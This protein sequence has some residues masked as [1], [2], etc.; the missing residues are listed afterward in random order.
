MKSSKVVHVSIIVAIV[1]I[2]LADIRQATAE[3][4]SL[5]ERFEQ[6][7]AKGKPQTI[8][9]LLK[10]RKVP[11]VSVALI[12]N[13]EIEWTQGYGIA[14]VE[15][16]DAVTPTTLFQAA[17]ISK[18]VSAM[19]AL[20]AAQDGVFDLDDNINDL[21][22]SWQ[23]PVNELTKTTPVTPR[24][25]L[26]HTGGTTIHGFGGY[27]PNVEIPTVVQLL[28]GEKPANSGAVIVDIAPGTEWRYS[29]GGTTIMQLA[30]ID[31]LNKPFPDILKEL[32]LD[33]IGMTNS[34][35]D[36]PLS[37]ERNRTAARAHN[38][39]GEAMGAKWHVYP[40]LQAAGLWT[41]PTD[42]CR[43]TVDLMNAFGGKSDTILS[44]STA[45]MMVTAVEPGDYGLGLSVSKRDDVTRAG[46][47]GSN[48]GFR[49]QLEFNLDSGN[50]FCIM[51]NGDAGQ[52][53]VNE[54]KRRFASVYDW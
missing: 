4:S 9:E 47:G 49:C 21:L 23:L 38:G 12:R 8:E 1:A 17:S 24:M 44:Q 19:A 14:D 5:Q 39:R 53:V 46:H 18:P 25:L 52:V 31:L 2:G 51:T 41:T 45:Q 34:G 33:P 35:F 11:G 10:R 36:Q 32:V 29:G 43:F 15:T 6:Q 30:M 28:N 54:L 50:G 48:W 42:L 7:S 27:R 40:E 3:D 37:P 20:R 26:S 13:F 22:K 16:G